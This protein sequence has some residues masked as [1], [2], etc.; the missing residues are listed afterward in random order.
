MEELE[1][2]MQEVVDEAVRKV[3]GHAVSFTADTEAKRTIVKAFFKFNEL[4][5]DFEDAYDLSMFQE[6]LEPNS[7]SGELTVHGEYVARFLQ[8][9]DL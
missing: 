2:S 7:G 5:P 4:V 1:K 6:N 8:L 3:R 9:S